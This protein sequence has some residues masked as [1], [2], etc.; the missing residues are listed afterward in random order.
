MKYVSTANSKMTDEGRSKTRLP[1]VNSVY[2]RP[3]EWKHHVKWNWKFEVFFQPHLSKDLAD[4]WWSD[5]I[6]F[7]SQHVV[8]HIITLRG[9]KTKKE[10][11]L[12]KNRKTENPE[13]KNNDFFFYYF[14]QIIMT[15]KKKS[16]HLLPSIIWNI[17]SCLAIKCE[18]MLKWLLMS[19]FAH[20]SFFPLERKYQNKS[21]D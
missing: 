19:Y 9:G 2:K 8:S 7:R 10:R 17:I 16:W 15:I 18:K 5:E 14:S 12:T 1:D 3:A 4:F 20:K 6:S 11:I 13:C 21:T